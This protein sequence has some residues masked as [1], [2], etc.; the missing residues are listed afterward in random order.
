[1]GRLINTEKNPENSNT[2]KFSLAKV[3]KKDM[4]D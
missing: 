3:I 2:E 4:P 1:M